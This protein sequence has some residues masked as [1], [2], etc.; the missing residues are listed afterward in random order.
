MI[1]VY[2]NHGLGNQMFQYAFGMIL[3]KKNKGI[4]VAYDITCL[5]ARIEGRKSWN[6]NDIFDC[7][8]PIASP[9]LVW[10]VTKCCPFIYRMWLK[11]EKR[12]DEYRDR[13]IQC[14]VLKEPAKYKGEGSIEK[15]NAHRFVQH[16][17]HYVWGFWENVNYL[18]GYEKLIQRKFRFKHRFNTEEKDK[19]RDIFEKNSVAVHIRRGD[20]LKQDSAHAFCLCGEDYYEQAMK[21]IEEQVENPFYVFFSDDSD[22]VREKYKYIEN[23]ML[24]TG[25]RDYVDLQLMSCCNHIICANSTFSF[26]GAFLNKHADKVVVVP[27]IHFRVKQGAWKDIPFMACDGWNVIENG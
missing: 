22:Y 17:E 10:R 9:W 26:W 23:K 3:Q 21:V 25:N 14:R 8:V 5:R 4:K 19:Y 1:L 15:I 16:K 6:I 12:V 20:Y 13:H 18:K 7:K 24:V 2:I 11:D 27:K